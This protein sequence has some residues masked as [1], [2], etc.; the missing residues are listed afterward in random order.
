MFC[1]HVHIAARACLVLKWP[2]EGIRSLELEL[3]TVVSH[4][5]LGPESRSF[6]MLLITKPSIQ[7]VRYREIY[8][9]IAPNT[10]F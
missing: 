4:P 9:P 8:F 2:K 1:L 3:Q 10:Q 7:Y 5:G 6:A